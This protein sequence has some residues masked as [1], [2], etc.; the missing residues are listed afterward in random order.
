MQLRRLIVAGFL[1][2]S[3]LAGVVHAC[4]GMEGGPRGDGPDKLFKA[5]NLTPE[6]EA[7]ITALRE[8]MQTDSKQ[9]RQQ[10]RELHEKEMALLDQYDEKAA[11]S[12]VAQKADVMQKLDFMRLNNMQQVNALLSVEQRTQMKTLMAK[13]RDKMRKDRPKDDAL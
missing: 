11:R 12:V 5:L 8:Q 13:H 10:L 6:Q 7:K 4:P 2:T 9:Y 1:S 3:L